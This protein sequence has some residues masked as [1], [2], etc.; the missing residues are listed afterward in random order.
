MS[1][2]IKNNNIKHALE[3]LERNENDTMKVDKAVKNIKRLA[4]IEKLIV[5]T[6]EGLTSSEKSSQK[7]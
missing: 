6:K 1:S 5:K 4:P 7:S 3:D 2:K